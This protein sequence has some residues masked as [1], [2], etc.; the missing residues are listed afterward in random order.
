MIRKLTLGQELVFE[1]SKY[2]EINS[3]V[4][5]LL[6]S[7][8]DDNFTREIIKE[9]VSSLNQK[10][11]YG[12]SDE[13]VN[14]EAASVYKKASKIMKKY[15]KEVAESKFHYLIPLEGFEPAEQEDPELLQ[16]LSKNAELNEQNI[17]NFMK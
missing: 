2:A 17:Q 7:D 15:T 9:I 1:G 8:R 11:G 4:T 5:E 3:N 6:R 10:H 14:T 12:W 16:Q 13:A